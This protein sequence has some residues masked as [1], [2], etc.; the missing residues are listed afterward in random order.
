MTKIPTVSISQPHVEQIHDYLEN[1]LSELSLLRAEAPNHPSWAL[2]QRIEE[3]DYL[4]RTARQS[5][6]PSQSEMSL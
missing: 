3:I 1:A 6:P 2:Q 4:I 5:L